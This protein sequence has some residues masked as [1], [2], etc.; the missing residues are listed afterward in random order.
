MLQA[1]FLLDSSCL[2][3]ESH[4]GFKSSIHYQ[5]ILI[6]YRISCDYAAIKGIKTSE[7]PVA[8]PA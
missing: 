1:C 6:S 5:L 4:M 7:R 8:V 3:L 2:L